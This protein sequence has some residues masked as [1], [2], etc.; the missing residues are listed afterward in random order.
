MHG[1]SKPATPPI[2]AEKPQI[3]SAAESRAGHVDRPEV[4]F[5]RREG[6]V[7]GMCLTTIVKYREVIFWLLLLGSWQFLAAPGGKN[8][9]IGATGAAAFLLFAWSSFGRLR[10]LGLDYAS[11]E[12][13][14]R[15]GWLTAI[16]SGFVAGAA[17]FVVASTSGQN[18]VLSSDWRLVVLQVTLGPV[19]EEIVFRGYLFALL[20]W[21]FSRLGANP[22]LNWFSVITAAVVFALTHLAQPGVSWLQLACITSTGMIYG[23]IRCGSGSTAPAAASHAVY[24]LTLYAAAGVVAISTS[25]NAGAGWT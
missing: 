17:I 14:S 4:T 10:R 3:Q 9:V 2:V 20:R 25:G 15:T 16:A 1:N 5:E 21:F 11:W 18:M 6:L 8:A 19:L 7:P 22:T 23:W 12:R 13:S 24:N